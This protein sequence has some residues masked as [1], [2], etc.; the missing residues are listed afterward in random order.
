MGIQ[1]FKRIKGIIKQV[2]RINFFKK[3]KKAGK[4]IALGRPLILA[5]LSFAH[6][7]LYKVLIVVVNK[8][9]TSK[10]ERRCTTGMCA[11]QN[12]NNA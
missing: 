5:N 10:G 11:Y 8:T 9:A 2:N 12:F 4:Q 1:T 6:I 3:N 7:Q